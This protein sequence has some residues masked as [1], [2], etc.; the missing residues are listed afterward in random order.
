MA[1]GQD[2]QTVAARLG[3]SIISVADLTRFRRIHESLVSV[4]ARAQLPTRW[5]TFTVHYIESPRGPAKEV[6]LLTQGSSLETLP[7]QE[8]ES[9][10]PLLLRVHSECMTGDVFGS[11]RCD[12]GEQLAE[13]MHRISLEKEGAVIY[14]RQEGRGIGLPAKLRA[15]QLQEEGLDTVEANLRLGYPAD[16]REYWEAAQIVR[17]MGR[18][19]VRLLTNNPD[20]IAGLA[21]YGVQ[22]VERIPLHVA[23]NPHN[24]RYLQ[25]KR[26]RLGHAM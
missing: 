17:L 9:E 14:L 11:L 2:L 18:N 26:D 25:T 13:S 22:V 23:G 16:M 7:S 12:C 19:R 21:S 10:V 3:F 8:Q 24:L 5:G 15:Y 20:K 6:L 1:R 4:T